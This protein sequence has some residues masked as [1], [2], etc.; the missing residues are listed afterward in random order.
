ML[1]DPSW[2]RPDSREGGICQ[3][4]SAL[5]LVLLGVAAASLLLLAASTSTSAFG[6]SLGFGPAPPSLDSLVVL[7]ALPSLSES[8]SESTTTSKQS[9]SHQ[10]QQS[11]TGGNISV[12]PSGTSTTTTTPPATPTKHNN[13]TVLPPQSQSP[14]DV[15][16]FLPA[17]WR[18][19]QDVCPLCDATAALFALPAPQQ[20]RCVAPPP[21]PAAPAPLLPAG[22]DLPVFWHTHTGVMRG[23]HAW[24]RLPP[25]AASPL[26]PSYGPSALRLP[27]PLCSQCLAAPRCRS[28]PADTPAAALLE[29]D[30]Q[31]QEQQQQQGQ[32]QLGQS[33]A[34][35]LRHS[36]EQLA[37]IAAA[38]AAAAAAATAAAVAAGVS[39]AAARFEGEYLPSRAPANASAES[40][41]GVSPV[42]AP[43][44]LLS[45]PEAAAAAAA[46][47]A[48]LRALRAVVYRPGFRA[49]AAAVAVPAAVADPASAAL[50]AGWVSISGE[51]YG[52][53]ACVEPMDIVYT[54][55]NGSDPA[56]RTARP[57]AIESLKNYKVNTKQ[58]IFIIFSSHFSLFIKQ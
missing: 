25:S 32:S 47:A 2:E 42:F 5:L 50:S 31:Q 39:P 56:V 44:A 49:S 14:T 33:G 29:L 6:A 4:P 27:R 15:L 43:Q 13:V 1:D 8:L 55:I 11:G 16:S 35:A 54:W 36:P 51:R 34:L 3:R 24:S 22:G 23:P 10:Y 30:E 58:D 38:D 18:R 52:L 7:S 19:D 28:F 53:A 17:S 21:L 26:G 37:Q 40:A 46:A 48:R 45:G 57:L 20:E 9:Q 41:A 12:S